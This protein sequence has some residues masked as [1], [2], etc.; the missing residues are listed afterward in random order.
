LDHATPDP[1][2][3]FHVRITIGVVTGLAIARV[4]TGLAHFVQAPERR[5]ARL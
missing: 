3:F 4:L 1:A 5:P 2:A